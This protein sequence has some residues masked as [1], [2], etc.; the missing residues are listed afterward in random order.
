MKKIITLF[1]LF[2][3]GII[4]FGCN[5]TDNPTNPN[6]PVE[7]FDIY[8][9]NDLHG[10]V[11]DISGRGI[12]RI[13]NYLQLQREVNPNGTI[14]VTA[15]DMLQG[16]GISSLT[17]GKVVI[18]ALNI[19][20]IDAF[21]IGNHEF[22]WGISE[23]KK[24]HD[25]DTENGEADFPF[26]GA[27]IYER[28]TN[29]QVD[30]A[31]TYTIIERGDVKVG[32]IGTLAVEQMGSI[33]PD[34]V[35]PYIFINPVDVIRDIVFDLRTNQDVEVVIINAH[36][37]NDSFNN[38]M[39]ALSGDYRVDAVTNGHTHRAYTQ[40]KARSGLAPL[41]I[42]Q[43]GSSGSHIGHIRLYW[44]QNTR[45][46]TNVNARNIEVKASLASNLPAIH[47]MIQEV[48]L[49][50]DVIL[51]EVLAVAGQYVSRLDG[52]QWAANVMQVASG[53]VL[54][55]VNDAGIRSPAFP[56]L[57]N[58]EVT[59]ARMYQLMPFDNFVKTAMMSPAEIRTLIANNNNWLTF[60]NNYS[61]SGNQLLI[62]GVALNEN[63][64]YLVATMDYVFD[65]DDVGFLEAEDQ[66]YT[67][68]LFRD[69]LIEALRSAPNN[70]WYLQ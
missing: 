5:P 32:I 51:Q 66:V 18:D 64:K 17:K 55:L 26:L 8:S 34:L 27:N 60:S 52:T 57:Q 39:A 19:I 23:I 4:L 58:E 12:A 13:G 24:F 16:T 30:W 22:D 31:D 61:I 63:E 7:F 48:K 36:D 67:G 2:L 62:D 14:V 46:I 38:A 10:A 49:E 65:Q 59:V 20:G 40:E 54:G 1:L 42:V 70:I 15:G 50:V 35:A 56:I 3:T 11:E 28:E 68:I 6:D 33:A 44:D 25:G 47:D 9:L 45:Q 43:A 41:P 53:A 29:T 21:T 69:Y 37:H